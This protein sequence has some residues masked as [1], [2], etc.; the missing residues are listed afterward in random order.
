MIEIIDRVVETH[1]ADKN[2]YTANILEQTFPNGLDT[3]I[4]TRAALRRAATE[5]SDPYD[6]EHVTPY[7][8]RRPRLFKLGNVKND[9]EFGH[10]RWTVDTEADFRMVDAVYRELLSPNEG[11]GYAKILDLLNRR[12]DIAAINKG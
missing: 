2:D 5:A 11:F 6:R 7:L 1:L 12:P 10:L 8:Y 9:S 4:M 3:E